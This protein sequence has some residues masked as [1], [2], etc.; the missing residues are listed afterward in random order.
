M[1]GSYNGLTAGRRQAIIHTNAGILLI[2]PLG[3]NFSENQNTKLFIHQTAF[4]NIACEIA[5]ILYG[6]DELTLLNWHWNSQI[7]GIFIMSLLWYNTGLILGLHPANERRRYKV[8]PSLIGRA[9]A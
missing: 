9:Q 1:L 3:T 2:C 8:T 6:G 5:A 7:K 4:E